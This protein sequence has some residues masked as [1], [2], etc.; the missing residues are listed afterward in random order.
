MSQENV[1]VVQRDWLPAKTESLARGGSTPS[2]S[3][4]TP[5]SCRGRDNDF[6]FD[7]GRYRMVVFGERARPSK[8][9]GCGSSALT[10]ARRQISTQYGIRT[11]S[12]S[13]RRCALR[14]CFG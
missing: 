2:R 3:A 10:S 14:L 9:P 4:P 5:E 13:A 6:A 11:C 8:P 7:E 12:E 1:E